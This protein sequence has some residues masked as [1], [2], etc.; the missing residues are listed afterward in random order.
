MGIT[1]HVAKSLHKINSQ[2]PEFLKKHWDV[3]N[4]LIWELHYWFD[5]FYRSPGY[6]TFYSL[7]YHR[8]K[9]H[10]WEGIVD[11]VRIFTEK[12][13]LEFVEII[14][15]AAE[16][17]VRDDFGEIPSEAECSRRYIRQKRDGEA[18]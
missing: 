1:E 17:H 14:Q 2:A 4:P 6:E 10:H 9:R 18:F 5:Y 11:A 12:Y 16:D 8:E 13:G 7:M 3:L 15:Q